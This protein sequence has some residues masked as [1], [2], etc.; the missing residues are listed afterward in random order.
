MIRL[1]KYA[2]STSK[3]LINQKGR[4]SFCICCCEGLPASLCMHFEPTFLDANGAFSDDCA[5]T[6]NGTDSIEVEPY[7]M[8]VETSGHCYDW[9]TTNEADAPNAIMSCFDGSVGTTHGIEVNLYCIPGNTFRLDL[10][11]GNLGHPVDFP[12]DTSDCYQGVILDNIP[13]TTK[14]CNARPG[15]FFIDFGNFKPPDC[16]CTYHLYI[17]EGPNCEFSPLKED[18]I[19][20]YPAQAKSSAPNLGSALHAWEGTPE[21]GTPPAEIEDA[22]S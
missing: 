10:C 3:T 1:Q 7:P 11:Y 5:S 8:G 14:A 18:S 21:I 13:E 19:Y 6:D 17:T 22:F 15:D 4:L 20:N 12:D 2:Q 9:P 16:D